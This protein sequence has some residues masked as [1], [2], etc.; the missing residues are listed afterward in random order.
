VL[1]FL[2]IGD[3]CERA[4]ACPVAI[5][6]MEASKPHLL[7]SVVVQIPS[8]ALGHLIRKLEHSS[9]R[10]NLALLVDKKGA[11]PDASSVDGN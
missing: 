8:D 11:T 4:V 7:A 6:P 1:Y 10:S 5:A 2:N 9:D 3:V